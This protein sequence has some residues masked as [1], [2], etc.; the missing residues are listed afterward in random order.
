MFDVRHTN[1]RCLL[2]CYRSQPS[3][4]ALDP[5]ALR[6]VVV[7]PTPEPHPGFPQGALFI[8][9]WEGLSR[10]LHAEEE[11]CENFP[12]SECVQTLSQH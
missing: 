4:K 3:G 7:Y 9:S 11:R 5:G 10:Q 8:P 1:S 6:R 12:K 2:S